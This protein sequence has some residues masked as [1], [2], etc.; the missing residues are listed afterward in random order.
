VGIAL[1]FLAGI[2]FW[3]APPVATAASSITGAAYQDLNRNGS[4]E[5]GEPSFSA[6]RLDLFGGTGAFL[7]TT[8]TDSAG[9]YQFAGLADGDYT[10]RYDAADWWSMRDD[11][12]TTT[13]G[14]LYPEV[15]VHLGGSAIADFGWRRIVRS[16]DATGPI[17]SYTG[18][19]GLVVQSFDDAVDARTIYDALMQGSLIG[20]EASRVTIKFDIGSGTSTTSSVTQSNGTYSGYRAFVYMAYVMWLDTGDRALFHEYGHA[21]SQYY[22]YMVQQ[23][24]TYSG[25]LKARGLAGDSRLGSSYEWDVQEIFA[26]DYRQLFG[27]AN[28]GSGGQINGDIPRPADVPGL[29]DYLAG[30]YRQ[31]P[32]ATIVPTVPF[33]LSGLAVTPSP[34]KTAGTVSFSVSAP[35]SVTV[36]ILNGK[37]ALVRTLMS[38]A[39][40]PAGALSAGWNRTDS[41]GRRVKRGTYSARVDAVDG[42]GRTA[43]ATTSFSV[44]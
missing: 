5:A 16:T 38:N 2:V 11:W 37:G 6:H 1:G 18:S 25:Y 43:T 44:Y 13:T 22:A 20:N 14:S 4:R 9:G 34:V 40:Q 31:P 12:V 41:A 19:N 21:W 33:A 35:G 26:E 29:R 32:P 7:A 3:I 39:A 36:R 10:V 30:A 27:T 28:A 17:S 8:V 15:S 23:D 42:T 24:P